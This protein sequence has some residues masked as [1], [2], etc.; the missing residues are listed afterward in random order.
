MA[1]K[2]V[3]K[4][5]STDTHNGVDDTD[6]KPLRDEI[7]TH[8][9]VDDTDEK[10]PGEEIVKDAS[11]HEISNQL[12]ADVI[13]SI[14]RIL[15]LPI[16]FY[17]W[18]HTLP[19]FPLELGNKDNFTPGKH[20]WY[21]YNQFSWIQDLLPSTEESVKQLT[22]IGYI[23]C[24]IAIV[25][26]GIF[27]IFLPGSS[28][29]F[30]KRL[31]HFIFYCSCGTFTVLYAARF[32]S[33]TTFFTNHNYLFFLLLVL[34]TLSGGGGYG[35][36]ELFAKALRFD[37]RK[38]KDTDS[39]FRSYELSNIAQCEF[40]LIATRAQLAVL[41]LFGSLWKIHVDWMSGRICKGIFLSFEEQG[42]ARGVPWASLY[43]MFPQL[44]VFVAIGGFALDFT[45][46]LLLTFAKPKHS[47]A[48][49]FSLTVMMFHFFTGFTMSQRIGYA[50]PGVCICSVVT[51][52]PIRDDCN[53]VTWIRRY[54]FDEKR[55]LL[56]KD[57]KTKASR[58]QRRFTLIWIFIQLLLPL[59][60]PILSGGD[61]PY[62]FR[63]YRYAWTMMLH[64]SSCFV[65]FPKPNPYPP[66]MTLNLIPVCISSRIDKPDKMMP[67]K[68]YFP[69]SDGPGQSTMTLPLHQM[70]DAREFAVMESFVRQVPK[71]AGGVARMIDHAVPKEISCMKHGYE[72]NSI[73]M[74]SVYYSKLNDIGA[75]HRMIDPSVNLVEIEKERKNAQRSITTTILQ[76]LFDSPLSGTEFVLSGIGSMRKHAILLRPEIEKRFPGNEVHLFADRGACL[77][78]LPFFFEAMQRPMRILSLIFTDDRPLLIQVENNDPVPI[79]PPTSGKS[80]YHDV[81]DVIIGNQ[82][83]ISTQKSTK[84]TPC[85]ETQTEDVLFA[86]IM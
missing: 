59:R 77:S 70:L 14:W 34:T 36:L 57:G 5:K 82:I 86:L 55:A 26:P 80:G 63:C 32:F 72:S 33:L 6:E 21:G 71:V 84:D 53:I 54:E 83:A 10:P 1:K 69:G 73:G 23:V 4:I 45:M 78:S 17:E 56:G 46:F 81:T 30:R 31:Q 8:D 29:T 66:I 60:T 19:Q 52:F 24:A 76:S 41:Y 27:S 2:S 43:K 62:T 7:V 42:V 28:R 37:T 11:T 61:F 12:S 49:I 51:F 25:S 39:F 48:K 20:R 38:E 18:Y 75:Y 85:I 22:M 47:T 65:V 67:R 15:F 13:F 58:F 44:F 50:F 35:I 68:V 16:M 40:A 74:K 9:G 64:S 3:K 79:Y